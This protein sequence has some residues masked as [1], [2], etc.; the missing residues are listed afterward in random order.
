VGFYGGINYGFG[1]G[2]IGYYGGRWEGNTFYYNT[3]VTNVSSTIVRYTY[4]QRTNRVVTNSRASFYGPGGVTARPI[5][6]QRIA[7]R[8]RHIQ[9]TS[10]QMTHQRN[11]AKNGHRPTIVNRSHPTNTTVKNTAAANAVRRSTVNNNR[12][13]TARVNK[14]VTQPRPTKTTAHVR[15]PSQTGRSRSEAIQ[16][17]A[18]QERMVR[19]AERTPVAQTRKTVNKQAST[20]HRTRAIRHETPAHQNR[21]IKI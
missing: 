20:L 11:A 16:R 18:R 21:L 3:A 8:E 1:Y 15:T 9:A 19:R 5:A 17:T 6:E 13:N 10:A 14:A 7:I 12:S 4:V 2:G